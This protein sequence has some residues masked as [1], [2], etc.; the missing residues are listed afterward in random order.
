VDAEGDIH[1]DAT[2]NIN[3]WDEYDDVALLTGLRGSLA[4]NLSQELQEW[5]KYARPILEKTGV[6]TYN[7]DGHHFLSMKKLQM[8]QIDA[9]RQMYN[10]IKELERKL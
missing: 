8:L 1:M 5:I 4:P 2:S 6:V 10:R 9:M 3:A 7:E